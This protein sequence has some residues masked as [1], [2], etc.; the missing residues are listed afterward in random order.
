MALEFDIFLACIFIGVPILLLIFGGSDK[1][2]TL[3]LFGIPI[4][5]IVLGLLYMSEVIRY[6]FIA[7]IYQ[8]LYSDFTG[9]LLLIIGLIMLPVVIIGYVIK[10]KLKK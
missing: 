3:Y 6:W 7:P 1:D 5:T 2:V 8:F 10:K 9:V 4:G